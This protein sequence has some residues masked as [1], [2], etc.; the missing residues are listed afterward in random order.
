[1]TLRTPSKRLKFPKWMLPMAALVCVFSLVLKIVFRPA[2]IDVEARRF[3]E[4]FLAGESSNIASMIPDYELSKLRM[5]R[6]EAQRFLDE[7][8]APMVK[9]VRILGL[10]SISVGGDTSAAVNAK[11]Q[12]GSDTPFIVGIDMH[13][14]DE[15]TAVLLRNL[16]S[17]A[18]EIDFVRQTK[19]KFRDRLFIDAC[20]WGITRDRAKL[21]QYGFAGFVSENESLPLTSFDAALAS[22]AR[23]RKGGETSDQH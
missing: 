15:G 12:V 3:T 8:V 20:M 7:Y 16:L 18:W 21:A 13:R 17:T 23:T 22:L 4:K 2:P 5:S 1:M 11:V 6:S 19:P 10:E 14:S 9:G